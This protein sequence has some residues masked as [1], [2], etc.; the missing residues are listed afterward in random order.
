MI[1]VIVGPTGVG[2]TALSIALAKALNTE[3]ISCD[4][5]QI[6]KGLNIGSAKIKPSEQS[7]IK[8]YMI[9]ILEPTEAFS[10]AQYQHEVRALIDE[11]IEKGKTPLLV[12]GTGFY[13][14]SVLH[15]YNFDQSHRD[16]DFEASYDL[17]SNIELFEYL[18]RL[19]PASTNKLHPNNRKRVLQALYRAKQG[20]KISDQNK[21]HE[22][23]Y[24]Y[25]MIGLTM[26]K[27]QLYQRINERVDAMI[28][29]GL[30]EEVR[31]LYDRGI[32]NQ[33]IEAIGYKELYAYF[34]GLISLEEAITTI[35][36]NSRRYAKRQYTFFNNQF[37]VNWFEVNVNDFDQTIQAVLNYIQKHE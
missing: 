13:L 2:K 20:V 27:E 14:K 21:G 31:S 17:V 36:R 1:Y 29:E 22:K 8:H 37:E 25:T 18:K 5:I 35:K 26:P 6:Y 10:V 24:D 23:L 19:D 7:G 28:G 4:S 34:E 32:K 3:I 16:L 9:D 15:N 30:I 33:S 11:F 12:G